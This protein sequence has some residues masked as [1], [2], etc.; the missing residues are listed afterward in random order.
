[1]DWAERIEAEYFAK[2]FLTLKQR[3]ACRIQALARGFLYRKQNKQPLGNTATSLLLRSPELSPIESEQVSETLIHAKDKENATP[4]VYSGEFRLP[5]A[6]EEFNQND[7]VNVSIQVEECLDPYALRF[8]VNAL[9]EK[10]VF[11]RSVDSA[12]LEKLLNPLFER[13]DKG[14]DLR[15]SKER[16]RDNSILR[17]VRTGKP[18]KR[19]A[20]ITWIVDR[21]WFDQSSGKELELCLG[22]QSTSE[23]LKLTQNRGWFSQERRSFD[24]AE[25]KARPRAQTWDARQKNR[26]VREA[27]QV[28]YIDNNQL[29]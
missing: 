2:H 10:Q 26:P 27:F 17:W 15:S 12:L 3:A 5:V 24:A 4:V 9:A 25:K 23:A 13:T 22:L 29:V 19:K 8:R 28:R 1:M 7:C 21:M 11:K 6:R 16:K 20:L 18:P 14:T